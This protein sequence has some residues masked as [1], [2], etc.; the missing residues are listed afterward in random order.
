MKDLKKFL[1][2]L[3]NNKNYAHNT[4]I[5]Y[6]AD[7]IEFLNFLETK[8]IS[9]LEIE[10]QDIKQYLKHLNNKKISNETISRKISALRTFYKYLVNNNYVSNNI[11][12]Y[13]SLP[14]KEKKLPRFFYYNEIEE[15]FK[16]SNLNTPLGQR[17]QLILEI[18][19]GTGIRVSEL[20]NIKEIDIS[21][22]TIKI[23]GK[24]NKERIVK[25]GEHAEDALNLYL[26]TGYKKL[27]KNNV[28]YLFLNNNGKTLTSRGIRYILDDIIKQTSLNKNIFPHMLRHSF[29]THLLNE[30]CDLISVQELLGHSSISATGIYTHVTNDHLKEVYFHTHPRAR[31]K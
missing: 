25:F 5:N 16:V 9:Y 11:F 1:D 15:L 19:Y 22:Q 31:K 8:K 3:N 14:K 13:I 20:I 24:G 7:I 21:G 2:Y 26:K 18:L 27:N 17:N 12:S 28:E 10:Y 6:E 4:I 23:L 30:G 29:A